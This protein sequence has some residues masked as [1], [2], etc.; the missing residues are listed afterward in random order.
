MLN[1]KLSKCILIENV[2]FRPINNLY[3][4]C[5]AINYFK[6]WQYSSQPHPMLISNQ[7]GCFRGFSS[8]L[9]P[10]YILVSGKNSNSNSL[11]EERNTKFSSS[12]MSH[13]SSVSGALCELH[14]MC[15]FIMR[16]STNRLV[17]SS[18]FNDTYAFGNDA[19][20]LS[21][22]VQRFS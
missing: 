21:S 10:I 1:F 19:K 13:E 5:S 12:K 14:W 11:F 6:A 20:T 3:G 22:E 4:V 8:S 18:P 15:H 7:N 9:N 16:F 17:F 2:P